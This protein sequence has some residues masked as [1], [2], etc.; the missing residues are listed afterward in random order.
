MSR[1]LGPKPINKEVLRKKTSRSRL[2]RGRIVINDCI[3]LQT[4]HSE[5]TRSTDAVGVGVRYIPKPTQLL[6]RN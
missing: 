6:G 5:N 3:I 4:I 2:P 1:N